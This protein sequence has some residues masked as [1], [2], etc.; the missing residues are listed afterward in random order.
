MIRF[1]GLFTLIPATLL[2]TISFFVKF[3]LTKVEKPG[4][5]KF[6]KFV[7][8]LLWLSAGLILLVGIYILVTGHHPLFDMVN[9][10]CSKYCPLHR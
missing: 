9:E 1:S 3:A 2:L 8:A 6:G 4:L 10:A 7:A 5:R